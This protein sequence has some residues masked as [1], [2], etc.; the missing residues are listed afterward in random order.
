MRVHILRPKSDVF[1]GSGK[2]SQEADATLT[3]IAD[4]VANHLREGGDC[5]HRAV[6][7]DG[8]SMLERTATVRP[9]GERAEVVK[10]ALR[11]LN[12]NNFAEGDIRS[13]INCRAVTFGQDGQA[14]L[15]LRHEDST[16]RLPPSGL[17]TMEEVSKWLTETDLLD[18]TA[19]I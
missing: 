17:V 12:P 13:A 15:C 18:G 6:V 9:L 10:T 2:L 5:S 11:L 16:P 8:P 14:I 3:I 4:L 1:D 19:S 7:W